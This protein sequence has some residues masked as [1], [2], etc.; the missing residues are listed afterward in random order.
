MLHEC[1]Y[2]SS[3]HLSLVASFDDMLSATPLRCLELPCSH[4]EVRGRC[5]SGVGEVVGREVSVLPSDQKL[6]TWRMADA[7]LSMIRNFKGSCISTLRTARACL[8]SCS[9]S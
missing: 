4:P 2:F 6:L 3:I 5:L 8:A 9:C 1:E 7:A